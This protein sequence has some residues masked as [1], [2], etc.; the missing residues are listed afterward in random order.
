VVRGGCYLY[1]SNYR[2][3][4]GVPFQVDS[5]LHAEAA[6]N[7]FRS[8]DYVKLSRHVESFRVLKIAAGEKTKAAFSA[9]MK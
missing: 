9:P 1:D 2:K 8:Y 7:S 4:Y 6:N 3:E 5:I